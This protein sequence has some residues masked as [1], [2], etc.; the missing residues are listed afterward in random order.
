MKETLVLEAIKDIDSVFLSAKKKESGFICYN[1]SNTRTGL[2]MEITF[3]TYN[4]LT[5]KQIIDLLSDN[6][7]EVIMLTII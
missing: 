6:K 5:M 4:I 7:L 1:I 3:N 2:L